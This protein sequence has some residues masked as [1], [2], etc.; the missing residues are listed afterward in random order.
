MTVGQLGQCPADEGGQ[1]GTLLGLEHIAHRASSGN[2][3]GP[4]LSASAGTGVSGWLNTSEAAPP[5]AQAHAWQASDEGKKFMR[6]SSDAWC[7]A[8]IAAEP[9]ADVARA[10]ADRTDRGLHGAADAR[11]RRSRRPGSS[12][13]PRTPRRREH[14]SGDMVAVIQGGVRHV[15]AGRLPAP[16]RAA[17][18]RLRDRAARRRPTLY[19]LDTDAAARGRRLARALPRVLAASASTPWH[20]DRRGKRTRSSH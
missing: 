13:D 17:R 10:A 2:D 11:L 8:Y 1:G 7:D 19:A 12:T 15:P 4:A 20:R 9:P 3:S 16:A 5:S 14:S 18:E 6:Q